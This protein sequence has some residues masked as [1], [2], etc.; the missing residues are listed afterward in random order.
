[1]RIRKNCLV[2]A[3]DGARISIFRNVGGAFAPVLELIE[4]IHEPVPR[5]SELGDDK[6]G[7]SSQSASVRKAAL[8]RSDQHQQAEDRFAKHAA[9]LLDKR[10]RDAKDGLVLV[11]AP[12]T[13]GMIRQ[14]Y[15][16]ETG[17]RLIAEIAKDF[18]PHSAES[19]AKMLAK[20]ES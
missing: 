13:L 4:E 6:P 2:L 5:S 17:D 15:G 10:T 11:A 8:E 1:V 19:L 7:R 20:H 18:G 16:S 12:R 9:E 14:H 3:A